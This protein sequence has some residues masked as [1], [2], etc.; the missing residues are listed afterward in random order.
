MRFLAIT[1]V[2]LCESGWCA[3]NKPTIH[4]VIGYVLSVSTIEEQRL[5]DSATE[6]VHRVKLIVHEAEKGLGYSPGNFVTFSHVGSNV[7]SILPRTI[8]HVF[9]TK[10][11]FGQFSLANNR[12]WSRIFP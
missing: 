11:Q 6:I 7:S 5:N 1:M 12:E 10:N 9:L 2:F 3:A 8:V 4:E